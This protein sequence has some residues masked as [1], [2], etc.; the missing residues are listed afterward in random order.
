MVR[1]CIGLHVYLTSSRYPEETQ[2]PSVATCCEEV[3]KIVLLPLAITYVT[4]DTLH[5]FTRFQ[6]SDFSHRQRTPLQSTS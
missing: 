1:L 3:G 2:I 4:L 5:F 6:M